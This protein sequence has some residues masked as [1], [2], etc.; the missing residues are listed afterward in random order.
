ML[1][2]N[3]SLLRQRSAQLILLF[4]LPLTYGLRF[5]FYW[6]W[7]FVPLI[8]ALFLILTTP[9]WQPDGRRSQLIGEALI[10]IFAVMIGFQTTV[11]VGIL[12]VLLAAIYQLP[13]YFPDQF[14]RPW[15]RQLLQLGVFVWFMSGIVFY[16]WVHFFSWPFMWRS[17]TAVVISMSVFFLLEMERDWPFLI[18]GLVGLGIALYLKFLNQFGVILL[19]LLIAGL[20]L[21]KHYTR[22]GWFGW[23]LFTAILEI[24]LLY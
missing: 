17:L 14:Y 3:R 7:A 16:L 1:E 5:S 2:Q 23:A 19:A 22:L 21:A 12:L 11:W 9:L 10:L 20:W 18:V 8:L 13:N 6:T 24:C 4:L 15:V